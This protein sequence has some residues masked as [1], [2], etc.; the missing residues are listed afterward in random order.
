M[1][2]PKL[3]ED[4]IIPQPG[5]V[6]NSKRDAS[7]V[8][9]ALKDGGVAIV[10]T[11]VGYG[12]MACSE[13]AVERAFA[14]KQRAP[15]KSQSLYGTLQ[16]Q[17]D[18]HILEDSKYDMIRSFSEDFDLPHIVV[19]PFRSDHPLVEKIPP[20]IM[21]KSAVDGKLGMYIG[22]GAL[23]REVLRLTS[24]AGMVV[25]GSSANLSGRGQKFKVEDVEDEIKNAAD[26]I[27]DY[28]LQRYHVYGGRS[29]TMFDWEKMKVLRVGNGYE[30]FRDKIARFQGVELP[31]DPDFPV[32]ATEAL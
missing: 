23:V 1:A 31:E 13:E 12:L 14:S 2:I 28:G 5:T 10:P 27:V 11:E 7:A 21:K 3:F 15:N 24:E 4:K 22:G 29:S 17:K 16:M 25:L 9:D 6:P 32:T 30:L 19:A 26:I 20:N 8:F 18:I